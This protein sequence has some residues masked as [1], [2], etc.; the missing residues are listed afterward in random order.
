MNGSTTGV[1]WISYSF[2][3]TA[4]MFLYVLLVAFVFVKVLGAD[5]IGDSG[6]PAKKK[7]RR[8]GA[9]T[10]MTGAAIGGAH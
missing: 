7:K 8:K 1:D 10:P 3:I 5:V 6:N 4:R 9:T 2:D